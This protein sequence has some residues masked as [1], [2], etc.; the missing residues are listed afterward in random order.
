MRYNS[1]WSLNSVLCAVALTACAV[2]AQYVPLPTNP[3]CGTVTRRNDFSLSLICE[4]GM[5]ES[6][7]FA[8]YG[9]PTGSCQAF[10][11]NSACDAPGFAAYANSTCV[12][13][14]SCTLESASQA[15][16]CSGVIKSIYAVAQCTIL[17]GGYA[18]TPQPSRAEWTAV[19]STLVGADLELDPEHRHSAVVQRQ[20]PKRHHLRPGPPLGPHQSCVGLRCIAGRSSNSAH[21][22]QA[23]GG[24]ESDTVLHVPQSGEADDLL[25]VVH[26]AQCQTISCILRSLH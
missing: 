23:E 18:T 12:G 14:P 24:R 11:H 10:E 22:C 7:L 13:K 1:L 3:F 26:Q 20:Q 2:R 5:I 9:T 21:L 15:D 4:S 17:P 8:A 19:P 25:V 6:V 16:P